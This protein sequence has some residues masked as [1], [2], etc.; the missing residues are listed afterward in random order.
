[1]SPQR[2]RRRVIKPPE[3]RRSE[4]L[5]AATQL[6]EA[7]G[8][9]QVTVADIATA[10]KVAKGTFYLYFD[11][12][13]ALLDAL[14][15]GFAESAAARLAELGLPAEGEDWGAFTARLV[16]L[17]IDFQVEQYEL[18]ALVRL[19][20][21]HG[22]S[23]HAGRAPDQLRLALQRVIEAGVATGAYQ[24]DNAPVTTDLVY[25]LLHAAGDRACQ[26]PDDRETTTRA[27]SALLTRGLLRS[28]AGPG[29]R[30]GR[31]EVVSGS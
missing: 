5:D 15:S 29:A 6:F 7:R 19:P 27:A 23:E 1:M 26:H 24:V 18:H 12:K 21:R 30:P 25:D 17:A 11:S 13:E 20:H 31:R 22:E 10:A 16:T 8:Y 28:P 3:V 9:E 14:R 4:L 2:R